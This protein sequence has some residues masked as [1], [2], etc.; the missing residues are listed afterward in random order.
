MK[1]CYSSKHLQSPPIR[2]R[3]ATAALVFPQVTIVDRISNDFLHTIV[4]FKILKDAFIYVNEYSLWFQLFQKRS[5][6]K[7]GRFCQVSDC[8]SENNGATI[9]GVCQDNSVM[10]WETSGIRKCSN[11][12]FCFARFGTRDGCSSTDKE[13]HCSS[14]RSQVQ[15]ILRFLSER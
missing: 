6:N 7:F 10:M 8:P 14:S 5:S 13:R 2:L 12:L 3:R 9:L 4:N 11:R 1:T 15:I